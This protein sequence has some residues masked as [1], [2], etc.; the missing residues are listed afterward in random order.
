M[1]VLISNLAPI[2]DSEAEFFSQLAL[3]FERRGWE[4]VLLSTVPCPGFPGKVHDFNWDLQHTL[5]N[6]DVDA[7]DMDRAVVELDQDKW[8]PRLRSLIKQGPGSEDVDWTFRQLAG[9]S[10]SL[11]D[12]VSPDLFLAWNHLCPHAGVLHDLCASRGIAT[13]LIERAI[14]PDTWFLAPGGLLGHDCAA[15][16]SWRELDLSDS[17]LQQFCRTGLTYIADADFTHFDKYAQQ[18]DPAALD[19]LTARAAELAGPKIVFFPPDDG[20]LG[21]V[22]VEHDDRRA[23]LPQYNSSLEASYALARQSD[24]LVVFK[25]HPSL[26]VEHDPSAPANHVIADIDYRL[27][28]E[29]SDV[30]ASTG[31]GLSLIALLSNRPVLDLAHDL[32]RG[33]G[34]CEEPDP[35]AL[36]EAVRRAATKGLSPE[37]RERIAT[38]VGWLL[39]R[40]LVTLDG[41]HEAWRTANDAVT[42]LLEDLDL[43]TV[44]R[45]AAQVTSW[46]ERIGTSTLEEDLGGA[47]TAA[48]LLDVDHTLLLGNSTEIFLASAR[49][50]WLALLLSTLA[51]WI[52]RRP[53]VRRV[54]RR[55][56]R[57]QFRV[58]AVCC[59]LPWSVLLWQW[60]G[61]KIG[62]RLL[63]RDLV[64]LVSSPQRRVITISNGF[65]RI[66]RP[67]LHGAAV[68][69]PLIA[70][71]LNPLRPTVRTRG[72]VEAVRNHF[73]ALKLDRAIGVSD[74][75]ED[76]PFLA[77]CGQGHLLQWPHLWSCSPAYMPFRFTAQA[78]YNVSGLIWQVFAVD[79]PLVLL[80]WANALPQAA[81][82]L[83]LFAAMHIVYEWGYFDNQFGTL[84]RESH[85][86]THPAQERFR[87]YPIRRMGLI[88]HVSL[89]GAAFGLL[90]IT[91]AT[92]I[93]LWAGAMVALLLT[94]LVYNRMPTAGRMAVYPVLQVFKYGAVGV[95]LGAPAIAGVAVLLA[96]VLWQTTH[97]WVYRMG[98]NE[99][100]L[101]SIA[102]R[103]VLYAGLALGL[104]A[105]LPAGAEGDSFWPRFLVICA[106][107]PF[108][109]K[110]LQHIYRS[111]RPAARALAAHVPWRTLA[112]MATA[113]HRWQARPTVCFY[114][115][116]RSAA[117]CT[118]QWSRA[119]WYLPQ[120]DG[121][122][123][124]VWFGCT[125]EARPGP[126]PASMGDYT[127]NTSH[128]QI[129]GSRL[130][131]L[132]HLLR[133]RL[134]VQWDGRSSLWLRLLTLIGHTI[135]DVRQDEHVHEWGAY[136][137]IM[138]R[139]RSPRRQQEIINR[140]QSRFETAARSAVA[141]HDSDAVLLLGTGP[142][143]RDVALWQL[144]DMPAVACNTVM[145]D[146]DLL[147]RLDVR[148]LTFGDCVS[149]LGVSAYATR[150]RTDL[151]KAMSKHTF[152][153]VTTT[154]FGQV[155]VDQHP[156]IEHRVILIPDGPSGPAADLW[157][158][159]MCPRLD[160]TLNMHM[161]PVAGSIG[162]TLLFA[163]FDGKPTDGTCEEDFWAH[164]DRLQYSAGLVETGHQ[165]HRAFDAHRQ[166][167]TPQRFMQ[168]CEA[169]VACLEAAD[170]HVFS[171][172]DS[173]TPAFS[174]RCCAPWRAMTAGVLPIGRLHQLAIDRW[175]PVC[176]DPHNRIELGAAANTLIFSQIKISAGQTALGSL[177]VRCDEPVRI[178]LELARHGKSTPEAASHVFHLSRGVHRL[179]LPLTVAHDHDLLRL[180]L[181]NICSTP[182][183]L[184]PL[185]AQVLVL[186][187]GQTCA[188][189]PTAEQLLGQE[190]IA[191]GC[192][193][194]LQ[195]EPHRLLCRLPAG[196]SVVVRAATGPLQERDA[197]IEF[198]LRAD[199]SVPLQLQ[200]S[201]AGA[202]NA[203]RQLQR[204]TASTTPQWIQL[205][206]AGTSCQ[207][208]ELLVTN[209]GSAEAS[210]RVDW[211]VCRII[212]GRIAS[213]GSACAITGDR[214]VGEDL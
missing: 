166:R 109:G 193:A 2:G 59:L 45:S 104:H 89:A 35:D 114:P 192:A 197:R 159:Y 112:R 62:R 156:E 76:A 58:T 98:G 7:A 195:T 68:T 79:M 21:F 201:T 167:V 37:R 154:Q 29:W 191:Q 85:R 26:P 128:F 181:Q 177:T 10:S 90:G 38:L 142:S 34:V 4:A 132:V 70:S 148:F 164:D 118:D 214:S 134:I 87:S 133:S 110:A 44:T 100:R 83:L 64:D 155:L 86:K 187:T 198:A 129:T 127:E 140:H 41:N 145:L 209:E 115:T 117:A 173:W 18:Q 120:V 123:E 168:S 1:R 157:S 160:S 78:K 72:K 161:I 106:V 130:Q 39:E 179:T 211:P 66:L 205:E 119:A 101:P 96:Q 94:F 138:W 73:P 105:V 113:P 9:W 20:T 137:R 107:L 143:I 126:P 32:F 204:V 213:E 144:P 24:G 60:T 182:V 33:K 111:L 124:Q 14:L 162:Q 108:T 3:A 92:T 185:Q 57:D 46:Q 42:E 52:W 103:W 12:A 81:A 172:A 136:A 8:Q 19:T 158:S 30:V 206:C 22:P 80:A 13:A 149:H 178:R 196:S 71:S 169:S 135:V 74:S 23:S 43:P 153:I 163:G 16:K 125:D 190:A 63:N 56:D 203:S 17:D 189:E 82:V 175:H 147:H 207:C 102:P 176:A 15:G 180:R 121:V 91:Q 88:W 174:E 55:V 28:I 77:A 51:A 184:E 170:K 97:Y 210:I 141:A 183:V 40:H 146:D 208:V 199:R 171:L 31:S 188:V 131:L 186:D 65:A 75:M 11:L 194:I 202:Q 69:W 99:K 61:R 212:P 122:L 50:R 48:V 84:R 116:F 36:G 165:C 93:A 67:M 47:P 200:W 139:L 152:D 95:V 25:P 151:F 150:F 6:A 5:R 53:L 54:F 27:L 49:P